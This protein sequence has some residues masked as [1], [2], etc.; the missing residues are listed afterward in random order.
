MGTNLIGSDPN[1]TTNVLS[2]T[3]F[4]ATGAIKQL[5]YGNGLRLEMGYSAQRQQPT[6]MK[7][8]PV[9]N[10]NAP[11]L[12]Y[13]YN[14]YDANS[15]NN[16]RIRKITDNVDA[17]YTMEYS[18]DGYNRLSYA[19]N[20]LLGGNFARTY[21][22]DPWGNLL[23]VNSLTGG[24]FQSLYT[25]NI[26]MTGGYGG[27]APLTNRIQ[28]VVENGQT[29]A[30]TY[31]A[32]GN[33][34]NDG[35]KSY[36]YDGA[37][38]MTSVNAGALGT[39]GYNGDG[40][41]VRKV[42]G[43]AT[44]YYVNSAV[45][46]SA[47]F[48]LNG[49]G[50]VN[51]VHVTA[52]GKEIAQL[53]TDGAFYWLHTDHLG[54]PRRMT[55]S[56]GVVMFRGEYDPHGNPLLEWTTISN[57]KFTGYERDAAAGLDFAQARH[58]KFGRNR[59]TQPDPAGLQ[60]VN[61][62]RPQS[63]NRYSYVF[64][65]SVN[66]IDGTGKWAQI[67][68]AV[69][70]ALTTVRDGV[71]ITASVNSS[72]IDYSGGQFEIEAPPEDGGNGGDGGG[73]GEG[74]EDILRRA[75]NSCVHL[76]SEERRAT[77]SLDVAN[78]IVLTLA[79]TGDAISFG[80]LATTWQQESGFQLRPKAGGGTDVGPMQL[81]INATKDDI[82]RGVVPTHGYN[83]SDIFGTSPSSSSPFDGDPYANLV[84]GAAKLHHLL[85]R[86]HSE[87]EAAGRY[88]GIGEGA[89]NRKNQYDEFADKYNGFYDCYKKAAAGG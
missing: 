56:T 54:T 78:T 60:A 30:H 23:G 8:A 47:A 10:P 15:H 17:N 16:N 81:N 9:S 61:F 89:D 67:A 77:F 64:N 2:N 26:A 57:G 86:Y 7:V 45:L 74:V 69:F 29:L 19:G 75:Y 24:S 6:S 18:Y 72:P 22:Y 79:R 73:G 21:Q 76:V 12:S 82:Q 35:Q 58:Y 4:R 66:F 41:R 13:G 1:A 63:L 32:A 46:G 80:L 53:A 27:G 51:R 88:V 48:E 31:D 44:T 34:T 62:R 55:N 20:H 87:R 14:Y 49:S 11:V 65:D 33:L 3:S 43:A 84:V 59:F 38:R 50:T 37:G 39:Y 71:T 25:I 5:D 68:M 85:Q 36:A 28:N 52:G 40:K 42:E 70:T 83:L